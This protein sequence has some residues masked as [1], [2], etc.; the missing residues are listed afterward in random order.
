MKNLISLRN[1]T[2]L[3]QLP[4]GGRSKETGEGKGLLTEIF[5]FQICS[6]IN[7]GKMVTRGGWEYVGSDGRLYKVKLT[8]FLVA[9]IIGDFLA[10]FLVA[11]TIGAFLTFFL[12]SLT[13]GAFLAFFLVSLIIVAFQ[14]G[15][16]RRRA[17]LST[18]WGAHTS[19]VCPGFQQPQPQKT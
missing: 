4:H 11:L 14:D 6:Q 5:S 17:G 19:G 18:G 10:F 8:N 15:V 12:V 2:N 9:L 3:L 7:S 1:R 13:I 16:H